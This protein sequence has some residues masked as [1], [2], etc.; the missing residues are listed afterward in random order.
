MAALNDEE[1]AALNLRH[2][3]REDSVDEGIE[4][5][6]ADKVVR[7]V[8][9]E[10]LVGADGRGK[11]VEDVGKGRKGTAAKLVAWHHTVLVV[12]ARLLLVVHNSGERIP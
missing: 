9:E 6:I 3:P 8:D 7:D 2:N 12:G 1:V 4:R 10:A 5:R 11:S